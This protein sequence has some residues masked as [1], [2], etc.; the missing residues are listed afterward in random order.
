MV[1]YR[2]RAYDDAVGISEECGWF[3]SREEALA[4]MRDLE[5]ESSRRWIASLEDPEEVV[6]GASPYEWSVEEVEAG[7]D[8]RPTEKWLDPN[9]YIA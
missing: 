3:A 5:T 6:P 4:A 7:D 2:I 9:G 1:L 8:V